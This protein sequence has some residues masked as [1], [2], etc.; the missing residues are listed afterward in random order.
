MKKEILAVIVY[1]CIMLITPF[2]V[3]AQEGKIISNLTDKLDVKGSVSQ[4]GIISNEIFEKY[5]SISKAANTSGIILNLLGFIVKILYY[6]I[7][8]MVWIPLLYIAFF[9]LLIVLG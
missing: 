7:Y 3:V 1:S 8:Y 2:T 6:M 9:I 4:F 5:G